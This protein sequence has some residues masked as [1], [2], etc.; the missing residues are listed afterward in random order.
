M[1][2]VSRQRAVGQNGLGQVLKSFRD[3]NVSFSVYGENEFE[4]LD[5]LGPLEMPK[6]STQVD[7]DQVSHSNLISETSNLAVKPASL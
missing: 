7:K 5:S 4:Y 1:D 3:R 2:V 6:R